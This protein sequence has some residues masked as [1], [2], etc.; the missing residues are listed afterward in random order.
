MRLSPEERRAIVEEIRRKLPDARIYLYGSRADESLRGGDIDLLVVGRGFEWADKIDMLIAIKARIG[1]QRID[2]K[3]VTPEEA[4]TDVFV[5]A[6]L[7]A[8]MRLSCS[9]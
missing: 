8:A 3:L 1:E 2:L 9:D 5:Q 6:V 4:A 7:P